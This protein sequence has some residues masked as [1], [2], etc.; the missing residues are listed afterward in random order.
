[1]LT[2]S[3]ATESA[4]KQV[5]EPS[6]LHIATHGFFLTDQPQPRP[7]LSLELTDAGLPPAPTYENP[8][9]RSGIALAG[10]NELESG[11]DDGVLTALEA[12]NLDLWGTQLV[13]LSAC[14]TGIGDVENGEGVYGLRRALV[15]AGSESQVMS[16]WKVND[17]ATRNLMVGYYRRLLSGQGRSQALRHVQLKMRL[18]QEAATLGSQGKYNQAIPLATRALALHEKVLGTHHW[19]VARDLHNLALLYDKKGNDAR[20]LP[21]YQRALAINKKTLGP[22]DVALAL[23][24]TNLGL[25]YL[26]Q[27]DYA[28][29]KPLL[30]RALAT[31]WKALGPNQPLVVMIRNNLAILYSLKAL[32]D[33]YRH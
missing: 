14:E 29:A 21:L 19:Y 1:M 26:E 12:A 10:A 13:V 6:V 9:L 27:G 5:K 11:I 17:R 24:L 22:H 4:L 33:D 15:L 25:L 20:A 7:D 28:R 18:S 16:L 32:K 2:G 31:A 23:T 30:Q 3:Q 8:L